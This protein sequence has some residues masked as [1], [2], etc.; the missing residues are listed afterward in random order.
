VKESAIRLLARS[1]HWQNLYS[2]SKDLGFQ[3][4]NNNKN[5]TK[6]QV[7]FLNWLSCY[8][9]LYQDLVMEEDF[10]SEQVIED[11]IRCDA[12]LYWKRTKKYNKKSKK[13]KDTDNENPL[14]I[15]S[16]KFTD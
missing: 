10:I 8:N 11:D 9:S 6:F 12:Y 2:H 13:K 7:I 3:L 16:V 15:P 4:F 14:G 5:L 1:P